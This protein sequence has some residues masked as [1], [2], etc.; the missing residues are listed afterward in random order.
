MSTTTFTGAAMKPTTLLLFSLLA[1]PAWAQSTLYTWEDAD[2]VVH[3]SDQ[4]R[5]GAKP[6]ALK[7]PEVEPPAAEPDTILDTTSEVSPSDSVSDPSV[8]DA[9]PTSPSDDALAQPII[10]MLTP[11]HQQ[12]IR[13]NSG[14]IT[15]TATS[16]RKLNKGHTAHLRLDGK[17]IGR[18]QTDLDWQLTNIDRGEHTLQVELLKYG[19]VIA[20]SETVTVFLHRASVLQRTQ[21]Q[22]V[23]K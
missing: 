10:S 4:P 2:G 22:P 23:P 13:D 8:T 18:A 15:V 1:A 20:S 14:T 5:P 9:D 12:T 6:L 16:N 19:K 21:P 11:A 7:A 17:V 3:F